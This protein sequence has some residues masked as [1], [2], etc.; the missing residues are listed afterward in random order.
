MKK[1]IA[2]A[3][4]GLMIAS[5]A[6]AEVAFGVRGSL[7]PSILKLD[8]NLETKLGNLIA[9]EISSITKQSTSCSISNDSILTSGF[10][11]FLNYNFPSSTFGLQFEMG[12]LFNNGTKISC[13]SKS[14]GITANFS[15]KL[16]Y[17]TLELPII[18]TRTI[19]KGGFFEFIPQAGFYL[20]IPITKCTQDM[21]FK[22][23]NKNNGLSASKSTST[24]SNI[25]NGCII[26]TLFGADFV[27][28]FSKSSALMLNLRYLYDFNKL[29]ID[30]DDVARRTVF[31]F[32]AGY[33]YTIK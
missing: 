1:I 15:D 26:G 17:T 30:G 12:F 19:N 29:K 28:N 24:N 16:S 14:S 13:D 4:L 7:G 3:L 20:S 23:T 27:F 2:T 10:S 9:D 31:L 5:N 32:S 25:D 33:R 8:E 18:F 11:I 21:D 22:A 6:I